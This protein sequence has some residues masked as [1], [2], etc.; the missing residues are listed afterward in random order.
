MRQTERDYQIVET[1]RVGFCILFHP[2]VVFVVLRGRESLKPK[3]LFKKDV[4]ILKGRIYLKL[5]QIR[6]CHP[7]C[8][9][10]FSFLKKMFFRRN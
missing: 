4:N 9:V 3:P 8:P 1:Q 7:F 2:F 6:D 5:F 10:Y